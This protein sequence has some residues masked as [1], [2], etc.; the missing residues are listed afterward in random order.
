M[1]MAVEKLSLNSRL[2]SVGELIKG[3]TRLDNETKL[4]GLVT[5]P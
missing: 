1:N 5:T 3:F 2:P 4:P